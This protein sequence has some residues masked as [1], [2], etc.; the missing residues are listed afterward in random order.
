MS[1]LNAAFRQSLAMG[2]WTDTRYKRSL[3]P[4][5][6]LLKLNMVFYSDQLWVQYYLI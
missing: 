3:K 5:A 4:G 1:G 6:I 2:E